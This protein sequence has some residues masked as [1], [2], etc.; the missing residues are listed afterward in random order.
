MGEM[1]RCDQ[2][3]CLL[4]AASVHLESSSQARNFGVNIFTAR[5]HSLLCTAL[6]L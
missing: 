2:L 4:S 1:Y 5:Q 6:F 3:Y